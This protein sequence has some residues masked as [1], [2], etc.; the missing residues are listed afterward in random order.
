M[1]TSPNLSGIPGCPSDSTICPSPIPQILHVSLPSLHL[2]RLLNSFHQI[3]TPLSTPPPNLGTEEINLEP[4]LPSTV[5][6][7]V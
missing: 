1:P 5:Q 4:P 3:V 2:L 7:D 6:N